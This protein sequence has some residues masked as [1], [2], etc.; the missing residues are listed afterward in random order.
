MPAPSAATR[1]A[2]W[3]VAGVAAGT[4]A[5]LL[6]TANRYGYG[7]DE[8]YF[9]MLGERGPEW[10]YFDQPPLVPS[11]VRTS[12]ELFGDSPT[13]IR[14]PAALC[15]AAVIVLGALICAELGGGRR[16]QTLTALGLGT[17]FLVL[18]IGHLMVTNTVDT[19][20]WCT[21]PVRAA[22]AAQA[23]RRLVAVGRR[24][25]RDRAVRQV[26]CSAAAGVAVGGSGAGG[27]A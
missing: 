26:C 18:T 23:R 10:G 7:V 25:G 13:G 14:V 19:V 6:A 24:G 22:C 21:V 11:L 4:V 9:R 3:P 2:W 20:V 17:S 8:L 27:A 16:A 1:P 5:L 15:A 12:A